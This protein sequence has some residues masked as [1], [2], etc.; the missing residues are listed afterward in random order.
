[1]VIG[2]LNIG[3]VSIIPSENQP[4]LLIDSHA[5]ESVQITGKHFQSV[6]WRYS[7]ISD[8]IGGVKL[9]KLQE[10]AFLNVTWQLSRSLTTED[11]FGFLAR[12]GYDHAEELS[13]LR[14]I[15]SPKA[16][17]FRQTVRSFSFQ[18]SSGC[19]HRKPIPPERN[20]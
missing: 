6:A 5:P 19:R 1:V 18:Q 2:D 4:P 13:I 7:K 8:Q 10:S 3:G 11:P 17:A 16:T 14:M 9:P 20:S 12:E 15:A